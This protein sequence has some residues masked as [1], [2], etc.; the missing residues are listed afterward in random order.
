MALVFLAAGTLIIRRSMTQA[1]AR[2]EVARILPF[3]AEI[4]VCQGRD[5]AGLIS[6]NPF[7]GQSVRGRRCP[8]RQC[9]GPAPSLDAVN[10]HAIPVQRP[11]V[12]ED[13]HATKPIRHRDVPAP[14]EGDRIARCTGPA[15]RCRSH[16]TQLEYD[17]S[18]CQGSQNTALMIFSG[19]FDSL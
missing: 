5:I 12:G 14:H 7:A 10:A 6:K 9:A 15:L 13:P 4:V 3:V 1:E 18:D 16:H 2:A 19:W 11:M 17:R 8:L